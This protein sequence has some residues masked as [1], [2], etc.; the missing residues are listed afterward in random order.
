M[1]KYCI[2]VYVNK[3]FYPGTEK[4]QLTNMYMR[5]QLDAMYWVFLHPNF[6]FLYNRNLWYFL[7]YMGTLI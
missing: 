1:W 7:I 4:L 3:E 2:I 5:S 6:I